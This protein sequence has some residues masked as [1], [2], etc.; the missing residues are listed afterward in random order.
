[1][2]YDV[3]AIIGLFFPQKLLLRSILNSLLDMM[4]HTKLE[5]TVESN[6]SSALYPTFLILLFSYLNQ[7]YLSALIYNYWLSGNTNLVHTYT[8]YLSR[9]ISYHFLREDIVL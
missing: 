2:S 6:N 4:S 7:Q 3:P 5:L 1:M 8:F 9:F